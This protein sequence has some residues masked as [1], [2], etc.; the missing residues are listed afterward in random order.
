MTLE[1]YWKDFCACWAAPIEGDPPVALAAFI[2][3]GYH[4]GLSPDTLLKFHVQYLKVRNVVQPLT[5]TTISSDK[6]ERIVA[7]YESGLVYPKDV[8]S[9]VFSRD[10]VHESRRDS[11]FGNLS[12]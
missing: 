7:A 3:A 11:L 4:S 9:Q 12:A 1:Q 8:I 2:A 5:A 10:D 6:I